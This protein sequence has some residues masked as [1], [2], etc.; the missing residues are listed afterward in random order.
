MTISMS[1]F[2]TESKKVFALITY[3]SQINYNLSEQK[4]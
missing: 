3:Y 1:N 2:A 4:T